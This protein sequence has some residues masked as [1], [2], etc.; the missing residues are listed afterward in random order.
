MNG[1]SEQG[2]VLLARILAGARGDESHELLQAFFHGLPVV[3]LRELLESNDPGVTRTGIW[4]A[5]ELGVEATPLVDQV[6]RLLHDPDPSIRAYSAEVIF[7]CATPQSGAT[8]AQA[9]DLIE[10][11][12]ARVRTCVIALLARAPA[13]VLEAA[14]S[15]SRAREQAQLVSWIAGAPNREDVQDRLRGEPLE[16]RFAAAAAA[17]LDNGNDA[18]LD[19]AAHSPHSDVSEFARDELE[20]RHVK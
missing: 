18:M 1:G 7:V 2:E 9:I 11:S 6:L 3:R 15:A 16:T 13:D 20:I 17:R 12:D 19:I 10:D 5:S 4:I 8:L 14:S